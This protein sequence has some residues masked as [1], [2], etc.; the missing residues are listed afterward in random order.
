MNFNEY[1][2]QAITTAVYPKKSGTMYLTLGLCG[3][4]G[5]VAEKVKKL[6]RDRGGNITLDFINEMIGELGD[7]LWYL[8]CLALDLGIN[9]DTIAT[10]NLSKLKSRSERSVVHGDGDSR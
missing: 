8:S 5:E 6:Y 3:E 7:V 9:L 10:E 2:K 4:S 1:Q